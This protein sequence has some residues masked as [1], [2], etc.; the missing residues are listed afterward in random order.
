MVNLKKT[1]KRVDG[2]DYSKSFIRDEKEKDEKETIQNV[3]LSCLASFPV[4][5]RSQMFYINAI[6]NKIITA[7]NG[8]VEFSKELTNFLDGVLWRAVV[9]NTGKKNE[10]GEDETEG[11]YFSPIISQ[12]LLELGIKE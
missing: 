3:I 9:K 2:S 12:V 7:E 10:K 5:D 6:S 11:I 4:T 1:L 8:E